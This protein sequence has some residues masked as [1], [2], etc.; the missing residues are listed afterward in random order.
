[1][2]IGRH[3]PCVDV[4]NDTEYVAAHRKQLKL[5]LISCN[6]VLISC[7][8]LHFNEVKLMVVSKQQITRLR[9]E[10]SDVCND[11]DS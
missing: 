11:M 6:S 10:S 7:H 1:M 3:Q 2:R 9:I 4:T 5:K 8:S